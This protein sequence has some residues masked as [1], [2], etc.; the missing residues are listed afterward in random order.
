MKEIFKSKVMRL[1][2]ALVFVFT[3]IYSIEL[4]KDITQD[5]AIVVNIGK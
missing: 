1:F 2:I 4:K 3:I 5:D